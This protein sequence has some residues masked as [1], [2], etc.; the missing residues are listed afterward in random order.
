M[1]LSL[2]MFT[3]FALICLLTPPSW[4]AD[5]PVTTA[6]ESCANARFVK[7]IAL[8]RVS[9]PA[10]PP[11]VQ[12]LGAALGERVAEHLESTG[13]FRVRLTEPTTST[14]EEPAADAFFRSGV[15]YF[16]RLTGQD[17]GI[18]GTRSAY[19]L[20]GPSINPRGGTLALTIGDGMT[21]EPVFSTFL[22]AEPTNGE[23]FNP[24]I[25]ARGA[26]FWQTAYGQALD[27]LTTDAANIIA[28]KLRCTPLIGTVVALDGRSLTIN[29]GSADGLRFSDTAQ[30]L[31]RSAPLNGLGQAMLPERFTYRPITA[32]SIRQ[33]QA[34]TAIIQTQS[35]TTVQVGDIVR[36]GE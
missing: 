14:T 35:N 19:T 30:I 6:T 36:I 21:A 1:R 12:H 24:P 11:D 23:L 9:L 33:L 13:I 3:P 28:D 20:F 5:S 15:P 10:P 17:F 4:A 31:S 29:R 22:H 16:V 2:L 7:T 32:A 18:G 26:A 34:H 27:A 25:D 8:T